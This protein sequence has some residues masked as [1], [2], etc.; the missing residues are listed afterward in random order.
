MAE[1]LALGQRDFEQA[2]AQTLANMSL[3]QHP[4]STFPGK[5]RPVTKGDPFHDPGGN[6]EISRA[7]AA[8]RMRAFMSYKGEDEDLLDDDE[9]GEGEYDGDGDRMV[10]EPRGGGVKRERGTGEEVDEQGEDDEGWNEGN[11]EYYDRTQAG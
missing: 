8:A 11:D 2:T 3:N 5:H 7:Q 10:L 9:W 1:T 4:P 6:D